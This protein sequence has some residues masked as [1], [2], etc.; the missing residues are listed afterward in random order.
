VFYFE[1]ALDT[2]RMPNGWCEVLVRAVDA[3]GNESETVAIS[4]NVQ[5]G[6]R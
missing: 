6:G 2:R 5:N 4:I 3:A 1:Y